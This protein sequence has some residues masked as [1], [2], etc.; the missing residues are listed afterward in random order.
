MNRVKGKTALITGAARGQG[1]S[2]ALKLAAEGAN[3]IAT[4]LCQETVKNVQYPL[5]STA[6]LDETAH[7]VRAAGGQ[8]CTVLADTRVAGE[9]ADVVN[10]GMDRFGRIDVVVANAG[11]WS[12]GEARSFSPDLWQTTIDINLNG[13]WN[14]VQAALPQMIDRG[15]G[16]SIILT[17]SQIAS[18]GQGNAVAYAASKAGVVGIMRA[19]AAELAQYSIRV[20]TI[21]PS[22][23]YTD[24]ILNEPTYR[25]F[26]P[27]LEN[28]GR[29]DMDEVLYP[30]HML[31][32]AALEPEDISNAVLFL[33]SDESRYVT[34]LKLAVDAGSTQKLG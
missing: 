27:E 1:R 12:W 8:I 6:Q 18:R 28:P 32:V 22:T 17:S 14:T 23:V 34:S 3:I 25:L 19:L 20:N 15:E 9:M 11:I 7:L 21:H 4:D 5:A 30:F 2:H 13:A 33:A 16:G 10:Q 26:R 31:P 29:E 24:M